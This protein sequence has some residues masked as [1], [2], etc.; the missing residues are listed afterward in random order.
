LAFSKSAG[1]FASSKAR[2]AWVN[3]S[4]IGAFMK[5]RLFKK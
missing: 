4:S 5:S 1:V 2:S 3:K